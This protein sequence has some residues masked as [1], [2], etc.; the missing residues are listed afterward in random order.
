MLTIISTGFFVVKAIADV[1]D[2]IDKCWA[3]QPEDAKQFPVG[4][5]LRR[6]IGGWSGLV[7]C[8]EGILMESGEVI[9]FNGESKGDTQAVLRQD[10]LE[11]FASGQPIHC[12]QKPRDLTH[13]GQICG[14]ANELLHDPE[15]AFN[16][17]YG[18]VVNNCQDFCRLCFGDQAVPGQRTQIISYLIQMAVKVVAIITRIKVP[19]GIFPLINCLVVCFSG[20]CFF[21]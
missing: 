9:H 11:E 20:W 8:H 16:G 2:L 1:A 14:K 17:R 15:N 3:V 7:F 13:A 21:G 4:S 18:I 12:H 6:P 10:S 5:I 19:S